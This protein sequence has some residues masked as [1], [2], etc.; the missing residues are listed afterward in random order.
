MFSKKKFST[1]PLSILN[2]HWLTEGGGVSESCSYLTSLLNDNL[3]KA[4]V[5]K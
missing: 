5:S 4:H 1:V 3:F 2:E